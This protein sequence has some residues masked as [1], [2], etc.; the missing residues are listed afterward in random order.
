MF[1]NNVVKR[2]VNKFIMR[3]YKYNL[4]K[5]AIIISFF[6]TI[7]S[8]YSDYIFFNGSIREH[9]LIVIFLKMI[10]FLISLL[11]WSFFLDFM[12]KDEKSTDILR[13]ALP[14]F[15]FLLIYMFLRHD[16][17]LAGDEWNIYNQVINYNIY[18]YHFTYITGILY[19]LSFMLIPCQMGIVLV[20]IIFQALVC[21][22]CVYRFVDYMGKRG[23]MI[24]FLF[25]LYPTVEFGIQVHRMQFYSLIFLVL[26]VKLLLDNRLC[27]SNLTMQLKQVLLFMMILFSIL[28]IWRKEGI[29]LVILTPIL[30]CVSYGIHSKKEI[31]WIC[32]SFFAIILIIYFPEKI[33]KNKF[34]QESGHTY[35]AWFVNMC[36]EGLDKS[37]Y[38][39]E[40]ETID[41][42]L[43][44]EAV[45]YIN[46]QLGDENYAD[47]Y[48]AWKK[49]Y[50]GIRSSASRDDYENYAKAV[51]RIVLKEPWIFIKTR[52]G[53]WKYMLPHYGCVK[54]LMTNLNIPL[55]IIITAIGYSLVK[56]NWLLFLLSG[57]TLAHGSITLLFAPAAYTKY[58]FQLYLFGWLLLIWTTIDLFD[59]LMRRI[60]QFSKK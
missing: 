39:D 2:G 26:M 23:M 6:H 49:G 4:R 42:Y 59:I 51:R 28:S 20:K 13:Y 14:Y 7:I 18:P 57:M 31:C 24:Y 53:L 60:R 46:E 12:R 48:I 5:E 25:F 52:I 30:L 21:G 10:F 54:N 45:D 8:F 22:Y 40:M 29:Y 38:P 44:L 47:E 43:S 34:T 36:R 55:L 17:Q 58:Y 33:G 41:K 16:M 3:L 56:K 35:N 27:K 11:A 15:L 32:I 1:E 9:L 37:K 19:A 50:V